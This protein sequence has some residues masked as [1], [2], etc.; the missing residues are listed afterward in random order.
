MSFR[1]GA[2]LSRVNRS[3]DA[4]SIPYVDLHA[5]L[6]RWIPSDRFEEEWRKLFY[7]SDGH[8]NAHGNELAGLLVADALLTHSDLSVPDGERRRD[9]IREKLESLGAN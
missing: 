4:Q 2:S 1:D 7:E 8:F 5:E 6:A 9:R 3:L